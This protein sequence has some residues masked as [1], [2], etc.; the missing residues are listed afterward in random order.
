MGKVGKKL[1]DGDIMFGGNC[2]D[3]VLQRI[4]ERRSFPLILERNAKNMG[5]DKSGEEK[6]LCHGN[7]EVIV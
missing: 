1:L 7:L 4:T 5:R 6:I 3:R 2:G